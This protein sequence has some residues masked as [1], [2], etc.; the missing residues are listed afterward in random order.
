MPQEHGPRP[1]RSTRPSTDECARRVV[2][3]FDRIRR[4]GLDQIGDIRDLMEW[5]EEEPEDH[6]VVE[7]LEERIAEEEAVQRLNPDPFR[8][9]T[10][11]DPK[12]L[13]GEIEIGTIPQNGGRYGL[14]VE[15]LREHVLCIGR[16]KGGK[17]TWIRLV[18]AW[19]LQHEPDVHVLILERKQ[20]FT[21]LAGIPGANLHVL[22][23]GD[24]RL[25]PLR[26]PVGIAPQIWLSVFTQLLVDFL[27]IFSAS[28]GYLLANAMELLG[29][30]G[31]LQDPSKPWPHLRDLCRYMKAQKHFPSSNESRYR[32]TAMN[33][34]EYLLNSLPG[35]FEC[36]Q[37]LDASVLLQTNTLILLDGVPSLIVQNFVVALIAIQAFLYRVTIEGHQERLINI[38]VFDEALPFFRRIDEMRPKPTS[39]SVLLAQARSFGISI[40]AASQYATELSP[41]LLADTATKILVGGAGR[42]ADTDLLAGTRPTTRDQRD[43]M[44][45]N[46][47]PGHAFVADPRHSYL[48][49]CVVDRP[50][51][52]PAPLTQNEVKVRSAT[53]AV[54]FGFRQEPVNPEQYM[55]EVLPRPKSAPKSGGQKPTQ[56]VKGQS[57][58]PVIEESLLI[59]LRSVAANGFKTHA[60]RCLEMG[61]AGAKLT[62]LVKRLA[63][64]GFVCTYKVPGRGH[65]PRDLHEVTE[66]GYRQIGG[67]RPRL[68]GKGSFLHQFYQYRVSKHFVSRGHSAEIEGLAGEKNVDVLVTHPT[69]GECIA[70]EIELNAETSDAFMENVVKDLRAERVGSLLCLVEKKDGV[71]RVR[72]HAKAAGIE[73]DG[74]RFKVDLICDYIEEGK[75]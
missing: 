52:V 39:L 42:T 15:A 32:D 75:V 60:D 54:E 38:I 70:V 49:E 63:A 65:A 69:T 59:V 44:L 74:K 8:V 2:S 22:R 16:P 55:P 48:I 62:V 10:P 40:I 43:V 68:K 1:L 47:T 36:S 17:T 23:L 26:P 56:D 57:K 11:R 25:N 31:V 20:E 24:L 71:E 46:N 73:E 13:K 12:V 9:T 19:I 4:L 30:C 7:E 27:D 18:L 64:M 72:N 21:E 29:H 35:V 61:I 34:L 37:G 50:D 6:L 67:N 53:A 5:L 51:A 33:R 41:S 66:L 3:L 58:V 28:S 14:L 45:K